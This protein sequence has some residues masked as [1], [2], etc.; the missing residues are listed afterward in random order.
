MFKRVVYQ[1]K[2]LFKRVNL[3]ILECGM[4]KNQ[5]P[6]PLVCHPLFFK[7]IYFLPTLSSE[8]TSFTHGGQVLYTYGPIPFLLTLQIQFR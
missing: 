2:K 8:V 7:A 3:V 6:L 5:T 4:L 1:K